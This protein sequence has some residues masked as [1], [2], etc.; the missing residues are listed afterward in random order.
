VRVLVIGRKNAG[1]REIALR[2][3]A[4]A[5]YLARGAEVVQDNS[6][7]WRQL[8]AAHGGYRGACA[9]AGTAFDGVIVLE[10]LDGGVGYYVSRVQYEICGYALE[11]DIPVCAY[12]G[13]RR[14]H[15]WRVELIDPDN[16]AG[17]YGRLL[18]EEEVA[19]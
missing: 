10:G 19:F 16:W 12:R 18:T 11:A 1:E 9:W 5:F 13:D 7:D 17:M 15:V 6:L 4:D 14:E 3:S 8:R 2:A